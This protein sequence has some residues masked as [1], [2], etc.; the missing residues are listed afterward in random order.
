MRLQRQQTTNE[1]IQHL[2]KCVTPLKLEARVTLSSAELT[3]TKLQYKSTPTE[4]ELQDSNAPACLPPCLTSSS[5][6]SDTDS[7][8]LFCNSPPLIFALLPLSFPPLASP[9]RLPLRFLPRL[10]S[11]PPADPVHFNLPAASFLSVFCTPPLPFVL[12]TRA[13]C[14]SCLF[15]RCRYYCFLCDCVTFWS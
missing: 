2:F 12:K 9:P 4:T 3:E 13:S 5:F 11:S 8:V 15:C 7:S 14:L 1:W 10:F 6:N